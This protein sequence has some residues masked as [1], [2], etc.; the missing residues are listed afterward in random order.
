MERLEIA[1]RRQWGFLLVGVLTLLLVG[2]LLGAATTTMGEP[3]VVRAVIEVDDISGVANAGKNVSAPIK[4]HIVSGIVNPDGGLQM[5]IPG[6]T[7]AK[8]ATG[9]Y[10]LQFSAGTWEKGVLNG[11]PFPVPVFTSFENV[12]EVLF[13]SVNNDGS[14]T[15]TVRFGDGT[16]TDTDT[17][18]TFIVTGP[19]F[20]G[21]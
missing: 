21:P 11:D 13:V 15:I 10:F 7:V 3:P 8:G 6:L 19:A 9:V 16:G 4:T 2:I 14:G 18:F 1:S 20:T 17:L 5:N 12:V